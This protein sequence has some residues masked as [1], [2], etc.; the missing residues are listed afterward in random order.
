MENQEV[1]KWIMNMEMAESIRLFSNLYV[2]KTSKGAFC[3]AQE[4][5]ALFR[6]ELGHGTVSPVDLSRQMG[7]SKP[8]VSRFLENLLEKG[9]IEKKDSEKDKRSYCLNLTQKGTETLESAYYYYIEP[10]KRLKQKL[11][12]SQC[13]ELLRLISIANESEDNENMKG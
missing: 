7:V 5:D 11:G 9:L 8:I 1:P 10:V 4:I 13:R 2:Q 6:I 12:S 3:S